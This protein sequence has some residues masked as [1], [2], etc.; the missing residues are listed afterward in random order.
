VSCLR[1]DPFTTVSGRQDVSGR[2]STRVRDPAKF[3]RSVRPTL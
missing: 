2:A 1:R 3:N